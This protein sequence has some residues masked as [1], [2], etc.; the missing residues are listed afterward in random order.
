MKLHYFFFFSL[1]FLP[2]LLASSPK[3]DPKYPAHWWAEVD[4]KS[5]PDWEIL[6]QDASSGEVI[7]SKRNELGLFSNF[8]ATSF[9]YRGKRYAS[10][11]GFWQMMKYP[12]GEKDPRSEY[13][14]ARV[15]TYTRSSFSNEWL[16][17]KEGRE[18]SQ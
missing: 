6:P 9:T 17:S 2:Q 4:R 18:V 12:E 10:I 11:E 13:P 8:G 3:W 5:A 16:G 14:G 15:E 1:F 7:L